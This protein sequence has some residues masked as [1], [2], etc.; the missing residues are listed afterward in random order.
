MQVWHRV[1]TFRVNRHG[2]RNA[3][4]RKSRTLLHCPYAYALAGDPASRAATESMRGVGGGLTQCSR[5]LGLQTRP[6]LPWL[7]LSRRSL[8]R[9]CHTT[10]R[11]QHCP[12]LLT[13]AGPHATRMQSEPC[14][15]R[16]FRARQE[17]PGSSHLGISRLLLFDGRALPRGKRGTTTQ[18]AQQAWLPQVSS[19][20]DPRARVPSIPIPPH[21]AWRRTCT[22]PHG[23]S[24]IA[25]T[26][27]RWRR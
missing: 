14:S 18:A 11:R 6:R 1:S 10:V 12:A 21:G 22:R 17:R 25:A 16:G 26:H 20:A 5:W 4:A 7:P 27:S 8:R 3:I 13:N 9:G 19:R 2:L 23:G 24:P 15:R